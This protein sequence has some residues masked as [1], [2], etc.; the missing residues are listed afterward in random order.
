MA[1]SG[2]DFQNPV[3]SCIESIFVAA[4]IGVHY[5]PV[6]RGPHYLQPRFGPL[7]F[8]HLIHAGIFIY[9]IE[10]RIEYNFLEARTLFQHRPAEGYCLVS[11]IRHWTDDAKRDNAAR[12]HRS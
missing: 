9:S 5:A 10:D 6:F 4:Y 8:A 12:Q 3:A 11:F 7:Q 2:I 1:E